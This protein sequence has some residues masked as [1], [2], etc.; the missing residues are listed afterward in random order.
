MWWCKMG[1]AVSIEEDMELCEDLKA[2][3]SNIHV[4]CCEYAWYILYFINWLRGCT[5]G[6]LVFVSLWQPVR[7]RSLPNHSLTVPYG[8]IL[9]KWGMCHLSF[10]VRWAKGRE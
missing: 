7:D 8:E 5:D 6:G 3:H 1:L 9:K 10:P 4:S 2:E